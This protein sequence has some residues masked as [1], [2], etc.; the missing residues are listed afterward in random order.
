V[1]T[2]SAQPP[3]ERGFSLPLLPRPF[4]GWVPVEGLC[5]SQVG[6]RGVG[7]RY[8]GPLNAWGRFIEVL[9]YPERV[10]TTVVEMRAR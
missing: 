8:R 2:G 4:G 1:R 5:G 9:V 7:F 3:S 6:R 10:E